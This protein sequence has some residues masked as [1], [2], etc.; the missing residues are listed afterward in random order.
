MLAMPR[1]SKFLST[2]TQQQKGTKCRECPKIYNCQQLELSV[3]KLGLRCLVKGENTFWF[4]SYDTLDLECSFNAPQSLIRFER[5]LKELKERP[6]LDMLDLPTTNRRIGIKAAEI[7][8]HKAKAVL[9]S[10]LECII[11]IQDWPPLKSL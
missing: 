7:D 4:I 9:I 2:P 3:R 1:S 10:E 11:V 5:R 8:Y 6:I